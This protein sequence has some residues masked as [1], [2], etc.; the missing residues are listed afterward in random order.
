MIWENLKTW[1]TEP[2]IGQVIDIDVEDGPRLSI[3]GL[4]GKRIAPTESPFNAPVM[5]TDIQE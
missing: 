1:E 2:E 4:D 3:P 5:I